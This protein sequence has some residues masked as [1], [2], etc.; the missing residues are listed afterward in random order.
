MTA[1]ETDAM[2][3]ARAPAPTREAADGETLRALEQMLANPD[4]RLYPSP[5]A[6]ASPDRLDRCAILRDMLGRI[7]TLTSAGQRDLMTRVIDA[8]EADGRE[9]F[10]DRERS[11]FSEPLQR[12]RQEAGRAWPDV[13]SFRRR[14][15]G[16]LAVIEDAAR[17]PRL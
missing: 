1:E 9:G 12:L 14:A 16:L 10:G 15:E 13:S 7:D 2:E 8:L 5:P 17:R 4:D 6:P 11:G 3:L